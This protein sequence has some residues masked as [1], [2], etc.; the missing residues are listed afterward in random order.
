[1]LLCFFIKTKRP[2]ACRDN[3]LNSQKVK[4]LMRSRVTGMGI[5]FLF[6]NCV[7]FHRHNKY[8]E[9]VTD[10]ARKYACH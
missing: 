8:R 6:V 7:S 1:M 4:R 9:N 5:A 2:K 10:D 3:N